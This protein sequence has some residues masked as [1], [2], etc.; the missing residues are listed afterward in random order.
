MSYDLAVWF[1][2]R[3]LSDEEATEL[4]ARLCDGDTGGVTPHPTVD[5]FYRELT[6]L[7]PEIDA[8]PEDRI[9]D[10]DYCPWSVAHSRSAGHVIMSCVWSKAEY[11]D[12][13]V[14]R[15]AGAHGLVVYDPQE[16]TISP[17]G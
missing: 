17:P 2:D 5:A 15:L 6:Q 13:L 11:V 3:R 12:G 1:P 4:Y 7:H 14:R 16:G 9:D 8:I 10:T